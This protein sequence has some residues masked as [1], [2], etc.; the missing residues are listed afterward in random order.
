VSGFFSFTVALFVT[1][2]LI[3]P[4]IQFAARLGFVDIPD[5]R[6]VHTGAIPRIGGVAMIAGTLLA[7]L[8][9]LE[10]S[11]Q[12]VAILGGIGIIAAF[13]IWDDRTDLNYRLKLLGQFIAAA[14]VV[15]YGEVV[16]ERIPF[17]G[18]ALPL[19][20][21]A[22]LTIFVLL[23]I[24]NAINLSDGLD[25]LAG[26]VSLLSFM[27]I[28]ILGYRAGSDE[29]VIICL[30]VIGGIMG[31]LRFNT[32]PASIFMGDTGSQYL[33][34][35]VGVLAIILTQSVNP[36]LSSAMPLLLFGLPVLDTLM[37]M[38]L[39]IHEKR[40][41]F[42]PDKNHI[43]HRLLAMG[44]DQYESVLVIYLLQSTLVLLGFALRYR[45]DWQVL[46]VYLTI[47][48]AVLFFFR[49]AWVNNWRFKGRSVG[50]SGKFLTDRIKWIQATGGVERLTMRIVLISVGIYMAFSLLRTPRVSSDIMVL[51][52]TMLAI[53]LTFLI[54]RRNLPFTLAERG[55]TYVISV[56]AVYLMQPLLHTTFYSRGLDNGF[57]IFLAAMI[58]LS[59]HYE[60]KNRFEITTLDFLVIFMAIALPSLSGLLAQHSGYAVVILK[61]IVLFYAVELVLNRMAHGWMYL[62]AGFLF[63][64][65][66]LALRT[67]IK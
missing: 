32:H 44:F 6:K 13:G 23:G 34:F 42:S 7:T 11:R 5:A 17:Y 61:V 62:R 16:I 66:V 12:T 9:W 20:L 38:G 2:I 60:Q 28:A 8:L 35:S 18:G 49:W 22:P 39:R 58:F 53:H 15:F 57:F 37:V 65:A 48:S 25:G 64:L 46:L 54:T 10:L 40:S 43:H 45:A 52:L 4:L 56:L 33:G 30:A 55:A 59:I 19:Y 29:L 47:C 31:F 51:C 50:E 21:S 1:M 3:P 63:M 14:L 36:N 26:G 41:P 67:F 27:A 24:T